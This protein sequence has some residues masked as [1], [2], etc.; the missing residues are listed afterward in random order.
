MIYIRFISCTFVYPYLELIE[1][2]EPVASS[3]RHVFLLFSKRSF[4]KR[5]FPGLQKH[6]GFKLHAL[7]AQ[8]IEWQLL[9]TKVQKYCYE[10]NSLWLWCVLLISMAMVIKKGP[11]GPQFLGTFFRLQIVVFGYP[12]FLTHVSR[13]KNV[14]LPPPGLAGAAVASAALPPAVLHDDKAGGRWSGPSDRWLHWK[15]MPWQGWVVEPLDSYGLGI[16]KYW[17]VP[18]VRLKDLLLLKPYAE[19]PWPIPFWKSE[20]PSIQ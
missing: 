2:V 7:N 11:W 13:A 15:E 20:R 10:K 19:R 5:G 9:G 6:G 16:L 1:L 18:L 14:P 12:V 8:S 4:V 3:I 17:N